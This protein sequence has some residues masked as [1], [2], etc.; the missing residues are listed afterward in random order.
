MKDVQKVALRQGA[1]FIAEPQSAKNIGQT[2]LQLAKQLR[3]LGF[4]LEEPTLRALNSCTPR[5]QAEVYAL[6]AD[7][8]GVQKNWTPLVKGWQVPTGESF[9]DRFI[10]AIAH[11]F[12]GIKG[13]RLACGHLIPEGTF[14][15]ERYNGCPF[16][17]MPFEWEKLELL[18]QASKMRSLELWTAAEAEAYLA[19]LLRSKTALD[20]TQMDSLQILLE[21]FSIP[22]TIQIGMKE[23][24]MA[25]I[26]A[27]IEKE[28][29]EEAAVLFRSP[30]DILRYLWY[31]HTGYLQLV[32]P[33]VIVERAMRQGSHINGQLDVAQAAGQKARKQLKLKYSRAEGRRVAQWLNALPLS[34]QKVA[35]MMH[36][37]REMW[38]RFIRALRL[39]EFSKHQEMQ[40]LRKLMDV[41]Y[42]Q[43][44]NVWAGKV[45][46]YR[47][48]S[49]AEE[50]LALL[51]QR[52]GLFARSLFANM[53]WFGPEQ[54]LQAFREIMDQVPA[55]L[56][57]TLNSYAKDYFVEKPRV[58][59]P[60]GGGSKKIPAN[61]LL[62]LYSDKQREAMIAA[63]EDLCLLTVKKRFEQEET[64]N[65]TIFIEETLFN[66]PVAIG[67][68]SNTIQDLP[69]AL[70]GT[71]F[72]LQ[73]DK[74]RLFMQWGAGLSAMHFDMDLSCAIVYPQ[75]V[76]VCSYY[77]LTPRGAKHSGD[78]RQIPEK[79][80]TAEYIELDI[81]KLREAGARYVNFTCNAYST[82][83]MT[84]N[85][86]VGWMSSAHPMKISE[87][88][89]VAYDP[90]CV[91][92]QVRITRSTARG[93]VFGV[94]DVAAN[95]VIWLEMDF[96]GQNVESLDTKST[97]MLLNKLNHKLNVGRLLELKAEAQGLRRV[98]QAE[99]AD[100]AYTAEWAQ[101]AAA[102]SQLLLD[103]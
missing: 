2:T 83:G 5:F 74:L 99:E 93:L 3:K 25:V 69:S 94:L 46:Q 52:P 96:S 65:S 9:A 12:E 49:N 67:D 37:Q 95:E 35:E 48:R 57:F 64:S 100:E 32:K 81:E 6:L 102:V 75:K 78:I 8:L 90:S 59:R 91:E 54:V 24:L 13:E 92:Q 19:D 22:N 103:E 89:G 86:V 85:M 79:V 21:H 47:L 29:A 34:A 77:N 30:T 60:L 26:D 72:P 50:T 23:T 41:F 51:K 66:M 33:K 18:G 45:E 7:I 1:I 38:I 16:C 53:L 88:S 27:L 39:P 101:N 10:T 28:Q 98:A 84:P 20:A 62:Q 63:I 14:P 44:Y 15:L 73:S 71:R 4:V 58:V 80:G 42:K 76:E 55:R 56:V 97:E 40:S 68:R 31:K 82:G 43:D 11:L 61:A 36:P 87:Q 17:G 70:M